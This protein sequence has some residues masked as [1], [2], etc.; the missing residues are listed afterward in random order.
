MHAVHDDVA[1]AATRP[2]AKSDYHADGGDGDG[3]GNHDGSMAVA[4]AAKYR[5]V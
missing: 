1:I 3:A 5:H 4:P 2:E